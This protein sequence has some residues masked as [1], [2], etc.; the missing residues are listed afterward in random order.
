MFLKTIAKKPQKIQ[1]IPQN[2]PILHIYLKVLKILYFRILNFSK[3]AK[4]N[5]GLSPLEHHHNFFFK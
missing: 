5:Y 2:S 4:H 3:L 1:K